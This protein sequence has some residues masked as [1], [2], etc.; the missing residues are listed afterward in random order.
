MYTVVNGDGEMGVFS[1]QAQVY[2]AV[3]PAHERQ[4]QKDCHK[5]EAIY[6]LSPGYRVNIISLWETE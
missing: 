2:K 4:K 6:R 3:V 1:S 5:F